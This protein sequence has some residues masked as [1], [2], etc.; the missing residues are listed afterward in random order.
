MMA[1]MCLGQFA[2]ELR[3]APY[4]SQKQQMG[5]RHPS[6]SRVGLR[7][8]RQF[9]GRDEESINLSGVL[10]PEI[11]GGMSSLDTLRAMADEGRAWVLINDSGT[12]FGVF[13]IES[14]DTTRTEF[15]RD[16][17]ARKIEFS[18]ELKRADDDAVNSTGDLAGASAFAL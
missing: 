10:Y 18:L 17:T 8:A 3:S 1:M 6:N 9:L 13:V 4:T 11:T 15:F 5:W 14:I 12:L 7:P 16:G 2:F